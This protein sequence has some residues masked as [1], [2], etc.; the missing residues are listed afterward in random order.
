VW[1]ADGRLLEGR[2]TDAFVRGQA[3][4]NAEFVAHARQD[5][6]ALLAVLDAARTPGPGL[7]PAPAEPPV[8]PAGT[9]EGH[10]N[11]VTASPARH[12]L[13]ALLEVVQ[14]RRHRFRLAA[15]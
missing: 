9:A 10:P 3:D 7:A 5:V 13:R 14:G 11:R 4:L 2:D 12:Q 15:H 6:L 1:A 8:L